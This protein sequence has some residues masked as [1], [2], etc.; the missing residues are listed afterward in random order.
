M[1]D[2]KDGGGRIGIVVNGSPLFSCDAL[3]MHRRIW[4][5][6][7]AQLVNSRDYRTKKDHLSENVTTDHPWHN[8]TQDCRS[9]PL[10]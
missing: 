9:G 7:L 5:V 1:V 10:G 2:A 6:E 4:I 3:L 8:E